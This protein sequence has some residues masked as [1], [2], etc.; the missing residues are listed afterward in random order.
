MVKATA[1]QN[2]CGLHRIQERLYR[3]LERT[4]GSKVGTTNAT[5][6]HG[7]KFRMVLAYVLE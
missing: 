5:S 2:D 3:N 7:Q 1:R 4:P 6:E